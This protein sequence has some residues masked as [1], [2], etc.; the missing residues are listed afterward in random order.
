MINVNTK[1]KTD[2]HGNGVSNGVGNEIARYYIRFTEHFQDIAFPVLLL[3]MRLWMAKIFFFSGLTKI[4]NWDAALFL[5]ENEYKV[6]LIPSDIAAYLSAFNELVFPVLL[7]VGLATRFA[8]IP[9]LVM[10]LVIQFT[11]EMSLEHFYWGFLLIT[12]LICGP[13]KISMDYWIKRKLKGH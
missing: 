3:L 1:K 11:Y 4:S 8:T 2:S 9:L 7:V 10:T 13:G 5:F 6:P 12:L